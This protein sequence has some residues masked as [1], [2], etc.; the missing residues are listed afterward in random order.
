[1]LREA[2]LKYLDAEEEDDA[3]HEGRI[4]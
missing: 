2:I 1:M 4:S 3:S